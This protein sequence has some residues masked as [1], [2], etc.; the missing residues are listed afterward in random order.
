MNSAFMNVIA[1]TYAFA[2]NTNS[3]KCYSTRHQLSGQFTEFVLFTA[4]LIM[5]CPLEV[6]SSR[7]NCS[8]SNIIPPSR[9]QQDLW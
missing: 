2:T 9:I 3:W 4:A 7:Q 5:I 1:V 6:L 8:L